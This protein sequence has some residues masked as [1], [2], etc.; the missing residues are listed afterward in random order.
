MRGFLGLAAFAAAFALAGPAM[1]AALPFDPDVATQQWLA[2]MDEASRAKSDSYFEGGYWIQFVGPL[3]GFIFAFAFLQLGFAKNI[4]AWLEKNVKIYFF[5]VVLFALAYTLVGAVLTF[6]W[7]YW[8]GFVR[9]HDYDLSTQTFA[10]WFTEYLQGFG[11]SL[12]IGSLAIGMLY[13]IIAV[14]KKTWWIWGTIASLAFAAVIG[15]LAPV[16]ISPIF[17]DYNPMPQSALRD[18]VLQIAQANGVPT[19]DV[20]VYDRSRQTNSVSANVSGFGETTRISLA[21]TLLQRES[22]GGVRAVLGHEIGHYVLQHTVSILVMNALMIVIAFGLANF[23]FNFLAKDERWGI[24]SVA[25]PAGMPLLFSVIGFIFLLATPIQNNIIR[26]HENQADMFGLN[27]AREPDGFAESALLLSEYRKMEPT[28]FEEWFFYDHPSG[29][30]RIHMA[31]VWKAHHMA[32][33]DIPM[34]P[35][36]PPPGWA[37]DFVTGHPDPRAVGYTAPGEGGAAAPATT[38]PAPAAE[39]PATTAAPSPAAPS[40]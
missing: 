36:G 30:A 16:Y 17:N 15:M 21:D 19:N 34:G 23:L 7:D 1:A 28:A 8:V 4:R 13:L 18:S 37:P 32:L 10:Q 31:M 39:A 22:P 24:R 29:Y 26:F 3:L 40:N 12:L 2:T 25:D 38:T 27:A 11:L 35:G 6:G 20:L 5:V 9:E 33:G 14:A